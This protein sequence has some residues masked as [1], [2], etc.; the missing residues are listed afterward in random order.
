[1]NLWAGPI[2]QCCDWCM[3]IF[4]Q[5]VFFFCVVCLHCCIKSQSV[6]QNWIQ[7]IY[8]CYY[9]VVVE[10]RKKLFLQ[11]CK[12][13]RRSSKN[14]KTFDGALCVIVIHINMSTHN[15]IL[16]TKIIAIDMNRAYLSSWNM[17]GNVCEYTLH[18]KMKV[19]DV[20]VWVFISYFFFQQFIFLFFLCVQESTWFWTL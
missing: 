6:Y 12:W 1:M 16:S 8:Y 20:D 18:V 7:R 11:F 4:I 3:S 13:N 14:T 2:F 15:V 9:Y 5:I 17:V 10:N 19:N